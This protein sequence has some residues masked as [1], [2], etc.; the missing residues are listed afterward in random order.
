LDNKWC[1]V[2]KLREQKTGFVLAFIILSLFA[3]VPAVGA[4]DDDYWVSLEPMPTARN[5]LGAVAVDGKIYAIGGQSKGGIYLNTNEMYD[6]ATATWTTKEPMPT[7]RKDF[8]IVVYQNKIHVMGGCLYQSLSFS[9]AH[10]VYDPVTDTWETK[11]GT[12][13]AASFCANVVN[14]KIYVMGGMLYFAPPFRSTDDNKVYDP[15]TDSWSDLAP[16]P[17]GVRDYASAV[18]DNKIYVMGG[19]N[20]Q[21][22]RED[23]IQIYD[24]ETDTWDCDGPRLPTGLAYSSA[25]FT[26]GAL[27]PERLYFFGATTK[28][29]EIYDPRSNSLTNGA[30]ILT[31]RAYPG[32]ANLNDAIYV[33][34][35]SQTTENNKLTFL[36]TTERYI[37]VG[38]TG[39]IKPPDHVSPIITV[40]SPQNTTYATSDVN[41]S[42]TVDEETSWTGYSLNM[43][44]NVTTTKNT[45]TLTGLPNGA[46]NITVYA[47]DTSGNTGKSELI[48]FTVDVPPTDWTTAAILVAAVAGAAVILVYLKTRK[49][50]TR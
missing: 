27:A 12:D 40:D 23:L 41:L 2:L 1:Q 6:P 9:Q 11:K 48:C 28:R 39:D 17:V 5:Y 7:S 34:G 16:M 25:G 35:G 19:V 49:N 13:F 33:I 32:V 50:R 20:T 42:F 14:G 15:L 24:P 22:N 45:V 46:H 36:S 18:I 47:N 44:D 30:P 43:E 31:P 3:V 26:S 29:T 8:G 38:Y 10:E 4:S 21:G 37:P